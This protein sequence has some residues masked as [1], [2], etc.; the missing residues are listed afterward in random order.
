VDYAS[1]KIA[2]RGVARL[3]AVDNGGNGYYYGGFYG[4]FWY[5]WYNGADVLQVGNDALAFRRWVPTYDGSGNY[6]TSQQLLYLMDLED[7]DAPSVASTVITGDANGWWGNMRTVGDQLYAS[8]YE[9]ERAASYDGQ[10]WDPGVVRYYVDRIDYSDRANPSVGQKINVPGLLVG[11]SETDPSLIYTID[12]RWDGD[13]S[14]NEF[15]VLKLSGDKAYLQSSVSLPGWVGNTFVRGDR[16]YM[17]SQSYAQNESEVHLVEL[18]LRDPKSPRVL[19]SPSK[20]G[21]GWLVG[22]EGDRALVSSGWA[23]Q[24]IDV[25]RLSDAGAPVYDQFIRTHGWGVSSLARQNQ[26]LF[27]SSGYWGTEVVDLDH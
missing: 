13:H 5:D 4:C 21:W 17:S 11:A 24:G 10:T 15:D 18:D 27:L 26:R 8:H 2:K 25:Y 6:L 12:Y 9:W 20:R 7:A 22:V 16:A 1:G 3:P 23:N 14:T 19:S